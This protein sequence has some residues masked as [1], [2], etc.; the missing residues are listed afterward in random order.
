MKLFSWYEKSFSNKII[1]KS[2]LISFISTL[3]LASASLLI[4]YKIVESQEEFLREKDFIIARN[5]LEGRIDSLLVE[6]IDLSQDPELVHGMSR[7]GNPEIYIQPVIR[8]EKFRKIA[9]YGLS[10]W[11]KKGQR[12]YSNQDD[13]WL[14]QNHL[15]DFKLSNVERKIQ[16]QSDGNNEIRARVEQQGDAQLLSISVDVISPETRLPLGHITLEAPFLDLLTYSSASAGDP[17]DWLMNTSP[18][19]PSSKQ[20]LLKL[21]APLDQL[22]LYL[23]FKDPGSSARNALMMLAPSFIGLIFFGLLLSFL[24]A[25]WIATSIAEPILSLAKGA[26][27]V[28]QFGRVDLE[29][30]KSLHGLSSYRSLDEVGQLL[31]DELSMLETLYALQNNLEE[32]VRKRGVML[33]TIFEL[34][35]DGYLEINQDGSVGFVNPTLISMLGFSELDFSNLSW[36]TLRDLLNERLVDGEQPFDDQ[37]FVQRILRFA[38]PSL[39][40]LIVNMRVTNAGAMILYWRDLTGE[41]EM[42]EM[43]KAFFAKIAHELR[44]PLTSILGFS[45]LLY[46]TPEI[47][48]KHKESLGIILRQGNNLLNLINDLLDIARLESKQVKHLRESSYSLSALTRLI[49]ADFKMPEDKRDI[50]LFLDENLP[51][52]H[53]D[54]QHFRQVLVNLLSN[55]YK[56]SASGSPIEVRSCETLRSGARSIGLQI[57]DCGIGMDAVELS[58][59]GTPFYRANPSGSIPGTGLGISVVREI[60]AQ[61]GGTI[62][63]ISN[64]QVGTTVTI[65]FPVKSKSDN[66]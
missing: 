41:V 9:H 2:L 63:F 48:D 58:Q 52:I 18:R 42:E 11:E 53:V 10:V 28:V 23:E 31:R 44:T 55:A 26:R 29:I 43:K 6:L 12:I 5:S 57:R 20:T 32:Q 38:T 27:N 7:G 17:R 46:Q 62:E 37:F 4:S 15:L 40:T 14:A 3:F 19:D 35:P 61:H 16:S 54:R 36:L 64:P 50:Q 13:A 65:W 30:A 56:Y 24:L 33:N 21:Q 66:H 59:L 45:Q 49:L 47:G 34:S 25:R 51:D 1:A 39:R 8:S 22:H 60:M